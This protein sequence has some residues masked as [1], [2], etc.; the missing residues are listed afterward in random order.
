MASSVSSEQAFSSAGI[1]L[2]KHHNCLK[3]DIV[4]ALQFLKFLDQKDLIFQEAGPSAATE[5]RG[6]GEEEE[7]EEEEGVVAWDELLADED[8]DSDL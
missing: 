7:E 4:E 6:D 2:S 8:S 3:G 5:T 1:T